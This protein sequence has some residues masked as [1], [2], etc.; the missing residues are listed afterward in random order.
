MINFTYNLCQKYDTMIDSQSP[1]PLLVIGHCVLLI[2]HT[3]K[4]IKD[5]YDSRNYK[6]FGNYKEI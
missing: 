1:T 2:Y 5:C 6:M 3:T 4:L